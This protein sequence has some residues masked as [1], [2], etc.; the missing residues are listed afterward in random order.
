[1]VDFANENM[2]DFSPSSVYFINMLCIE[3][4]HLFSMHKDN[5]LEMF[6]SARAFLFKVV[7]HF[8]FFS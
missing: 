1:V 7:S 5:R 3:S 2:E 4:K 8:P 6:C